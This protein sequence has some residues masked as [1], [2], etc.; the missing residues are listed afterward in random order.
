MSIDRQNL[1]ELVQ[2]VLRELGEDLGKEA[3]LQTDESTPLFGSRS[4]LDSMNLVN[5][6]TDIEE[7]LS[8]DYNIHITLAN[9]SAMSRTRSPFR[10]IGTCVDYIMELIETTKD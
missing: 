8:D 5:V 2:T 1:L 3:F 4:S 10:R 9:A 7:R 6:I